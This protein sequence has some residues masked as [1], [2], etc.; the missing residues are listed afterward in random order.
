MEQLTGLDASFLAMETASATGHIGSVMVLDPSTAPLPL[1]LDRL[2]E[3]LGRRIA[4]VAM[5]R[6]K[7]FGVPL[8]LDNPYWIED[9]DFDLE[10]HVR[11]IALP[12]PGSYK[13]LTEQ[14]ARLHGRRLDRSRPL[15][16]MYLISGLAE[17]RTAIY[18][19]LH[20]AMIDG[21]AGND[22]L[23]AVL[24]L[25]P[26]GREG[27]QPTPATEAPVPTRGQMWG[28]LV[29][30]WASHPVRAVR[31]AADIAQSAPL[32]AATNAPAVPV[33]RRFLDDRDV[34]N[35][36]G[37]MRAPKVPFN[38]PI[39]PHRRVA[40]ASVPLSGVKGLKNS[41]GTT[42]NDVVLAMCA[43]ALRRWLEGQNAL[44]TAPVVGAVPISIRAREGERGN[45]VSLMTVPLPTDCADPWERLVSASK[46]ARVAKERFDA[47]PATMLMELYQFSFPSL[48]NQASRLAARFRL[49]EMVRPF[50]LV[51]SNVP[52]P[53]IPL[54][55]AGAELVEYYP[56]STLPDG[57][58]LNVTVFSYRDTLFFGLLGCRELVPDLELLAQA[59][60][61]EYHDLL[62]AAASRPQ[63]IECEPAPASM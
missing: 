37:T 30:A 21:V 33:V 58:G 61:A 50:N 54:Y 12:A 29:R 27:H 14:V 52:G 11:E 46:S 36:A 34:L 31:I 26:E 57:Q 25:A 19:K 40:F 51:V 43:G 44:P 55:V 10:Y 20:H 2:T 13:Q 22:L 8:G 42:V 59:I 5:C 9:P 4:G 47:V 49:L 45:R 35:G 56:V 38:A 53:P 6:R 17:G 7:L 18:T 39:T 62:E 1:T 63:P 24:D 48:A 23:E 15:W 60:A 32:I 3:A 28:R 16:E 41:A